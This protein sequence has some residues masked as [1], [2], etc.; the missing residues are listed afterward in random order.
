MPR[1]LPDRAAEA[2]EEDK[3]E[4]DGQPVRQRRVPDRFGQSR[5][6]SINIPE[7]RKRHRLRRLNDNSYQPTRHQAS[8]SRKPSGD[9]SDSDLEKSQRPRTRRQRRANNHHTTGMDNSRAANSPSPASEPSYGEAPAD[10]VLSSLMQVEP[11]TLPADFDIRSFLAAAPNKKVKKHPPPPPDVEPMSPNQ[12]ELAKEPV[13]AAFEEPHDQIWMAGLVWFHDVL[14]E[15]NTEP[16]T[17]QTHFK[18]AKR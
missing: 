10:E 12:S 8:D 13:P 4:D 9:A 1:V 14:Q 7:P 17:P 18:E 11:S 5:A 3:K 2:G 15:G 6:N 16:G